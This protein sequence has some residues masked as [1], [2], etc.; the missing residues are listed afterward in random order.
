MSLTVIAYPPSGG[1]NHLKNLLCTTGKFS[2]SN[3]LNL[4]LYNKREREVH[5]TSDR[6]VTKEK[7]HRAVSEYNFVLNGHFGELAPW[8]EKIKSTVDKKFILIT[9][10][11]A[12]DKRLLDQRQHC[13]GQQ[14][15][16]WYIEEEQPFLYQPHL[17]NLYFGADNDKILQIP[18]HEFWQQD[19]QSCNIIN[20]L[21][22]FLN[23]TI[24][25]NFAQHL[26]QQWWNANF[27]F[28][29]F[30]HLFNSTNHKGNR[31]G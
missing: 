8:A 14:G 20:R 23:I 26:H 1:G 11:T 27:N 10:D 12:Q 9:I 31:N 29:W 4:N 5:S 25:L 13:L 7:I 3:D 21:N 30:T 18:L 6:N 2:N 22:N 24:D 15:H 16:P 19:L 17:Y 28:N